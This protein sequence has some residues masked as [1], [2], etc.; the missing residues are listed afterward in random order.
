MRLNHS[1]FIT[2][3]PDRALSVAS[4]ATLAY[5]ACSIFTTI[6]PIAGAL[7]IGAAV[8]TNFIAEDIFKMAFDKFNTTQPIAKFL[9]YCVQ[10]A[11]AIAIGIK[12]A[13]IAGFIFT[14]K[15]AVVVTLFSNA[16]LIGATILVGR[17]VLSIAGVTEYADKRN[18]FRIRLGL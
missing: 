7:F 4:S 11:A 8:A 14:V 3:L 6:N 5:C 15:S 12:V 13:T 10:N 16:V 9:S 1:Q 17:S 18:E 2:S